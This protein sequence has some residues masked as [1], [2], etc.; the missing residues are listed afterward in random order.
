[1]LFIPRIN[2]IFSAR[3]IL[4]FIEKNNIKFEYRERVDLMKH[5]LSCYYKDYYLIL[6]ITRDSNY[7]VIRVNI[8][9]YNF[10]IKDGTLSYPRGSGN[11]VYYSYKYQNYLYL[12][13]LGQ[14]KVCYKHNDNNMCVD[15][16]DL[17]DGRGYKTLSFDKIKEKCNLYM[18]HIKKR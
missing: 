5:R 16:R 7:N 6:F 17:K 11:C 3:Q 13:Y 4:T 2:K 10:S 14:V 15:I 12:H 18:N 8:T 1:M 9:L